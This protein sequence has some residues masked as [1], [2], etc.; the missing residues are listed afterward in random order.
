MTHD[1][2]LIGSKPGVSGAWCFTHAVR[3]VRDGIAWKTRR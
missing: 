2:C 3:I 1:N